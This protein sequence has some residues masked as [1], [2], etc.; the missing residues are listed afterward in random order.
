ML[1]TQINRRSGYR[2]DQAAGTLA[3]A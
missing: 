2:V 1:K 3:T